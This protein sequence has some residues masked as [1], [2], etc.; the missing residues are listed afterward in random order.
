MT[1]DEYWRRVRATR[2][3]N[4][5]RNEVQ[6][7][8]MRVQPPDISRCGDTNGPTRRPDDLPEGPELLLGLCMPWGDES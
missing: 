1:I 7:R 5:I 6:A 2:S 3:P 8:A 4:T